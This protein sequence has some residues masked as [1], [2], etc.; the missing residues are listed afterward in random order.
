MPPPGGL[1]GLGRGPG[2]TPSPPEEWPRGPVELDGRTFDAF[3][4]KYPVSMVEMWASWCAPC[5]AMRPIIRDLAK[6]YQGRL[7][8]GKVAIEH[9]KALAERLKVMSVPYIIFYSYGKKVG[10]LTGAIQKRK[11]KGRIK[12]LL[13]KH[14]P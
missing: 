9:H 10:E 3:I 8:I 14:G 4:E 13:K 6:E 11:L 12:Q 1:R 7:A 5:K 2:R